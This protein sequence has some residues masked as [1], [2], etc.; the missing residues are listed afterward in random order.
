MGLRFTIGRKLGLG[1][2]VLLLAIIANGLVTYFTLDKTNNLRE[3]I[4]EIYTPSISKLKDLNTLVIRS[5]SLTITWLEDD[6]PVEDQEQKKELQAIHQIAY[7]SLKK[8][9][10]KLT[11]KWDTN[12]ERKFESV[13]EKIDSLSEKQHEIM[14]K[15]RTEDD[16]Y[17]PS[18]NVAIRFDLRNQFSQE[19]GEFFKMIDEIKSELNLTISAQ[20]D[21][22]NQYSVEMEEEFKTLR[23]YVIWL[24]II[25]VM[26]GVVVAYFTIRS[27]VNPVNNLKDVLLIMGKGVLPNK[28][29]QGRRDEIGEMSIALNSLVEGLKG[30]SKFAKEIGEGDFDSQYEPLS[31]EDILGN[32]LIIMRDNLRRVAEEDRK[33]NWTTGGLA[34]FGEI[35]RSN[36][37]D[38]KELSSNLI[39]E[40][41]KYLGANQGGVYLLENDEEDEEEF[42]ELTGAY[43]WDRLKYLDQKIPKGDGLVGQAWQ[44]KDTLYI[45]DV[46]KDYINITSG[47]GDANPKCL[48]I[49]PMVVNEEVFGVIEIAS[50]FEFED[51]QVKFVEKLAE[52]TASTIQSVKVNQ[53]TKQLLEQAQMA[54]EQMRTQ[55]EEL[56]HNQD[57]MTSHQAEM[58]KQ[59]EDYQL[60]LRQLQNSRDHLKEEN[61]ILQNVL[62]KATKEL[63]RLQLEN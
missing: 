60:Q 53:R 44:E 30:T 21:Y 31:E 12:D 51:Y 25:L 15:F 41:V 50:F 22:A 24:G 7:P 33:R 20:Q 1:F 58:E 13:L 49:V 36:S 35:L 27:I 19:G 28:E 16:Y 59:I 57:E 3:K 52:T 48:L 17:F 62:L 4:S 34:K 5:K 43:A 45:T 38:V 6:S 55:E 29:I 18:D 56:R 10:K 40:L 37:D 42:L 23:D 47:L 32:S 63:E 39:S 8:E 54:S 14:N 26:S 11:K 9:L 2:G 61:E 46:P